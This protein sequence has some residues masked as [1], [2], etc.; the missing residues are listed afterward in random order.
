MRTNDSKLPEDGFK[1]ETPVDTTPAK[2][3]T[4]YVPA[5]SGSPAPGMVASLPDGPSSDE[6]K[7]VAAPS[8]LFFSEEKRLVV[9]VLNGVV[10]KR[11]D[12]VV[13]GSVEMSEGVVHAEALPGFKL[14]EGHTAWSF[15]SR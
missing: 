4:A 7:V 11:G 12:E 14:A 9:P 8:P 6:D 2:S 10:Y 13:T 5:E 3:P 15:G 1:A